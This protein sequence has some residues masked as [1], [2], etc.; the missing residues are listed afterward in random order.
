MFGKVTC[1]AHDL[2]LARSCDN[3]GRTYYMENDQKKRGKKIGG[4][5]SLQAV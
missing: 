2:C 1:H 5:V 4:L 3:K